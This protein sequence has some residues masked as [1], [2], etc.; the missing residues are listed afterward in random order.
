MQHHFLHLNIYFSLSNKYADFKK[1]LFI[2]L[3]KILKKPDFPSAKKCYLQ[4][5]LKICLFITY[6]WRE[7][8]M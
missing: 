7:V 4:N 2:Q 3:L 8:L 6:W 5:F 1:I